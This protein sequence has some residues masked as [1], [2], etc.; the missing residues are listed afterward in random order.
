[1]A[2]R[3]SREPREARQSVVTAKRQKAPPN[4]KA[5]QRSPVCRGIAFGIVRSVG[6]G[7]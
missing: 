5:F 7:F 3:S 1:M 6:D 4:T 2:P